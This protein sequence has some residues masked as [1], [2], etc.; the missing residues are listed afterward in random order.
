MLLWALVTKGFVARGPRG[1]WGVGGALYEVINTHDPI[2]GKAIQPCPN[3]LT[4]KLICAIIHSYK[5]Q[6]A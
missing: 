6:R 5:S 4:T 1:Q 2:C 3:H